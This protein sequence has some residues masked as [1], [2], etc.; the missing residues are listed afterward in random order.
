[1][2]QLQMVVITV[3]TENTEQAAG[4]MTGSGQDDGQR[5]MQSHMARLNK[6]LLPRYGSVPPPPSHPGQRLLAGLNWRF[7][8]PW[9]L[10]LALANRLHHITVPAA[11]AKRL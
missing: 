5:E 7:G 2:L 11:L 10:S 4:R 6:L 3:S 1:M 8:I 9:L